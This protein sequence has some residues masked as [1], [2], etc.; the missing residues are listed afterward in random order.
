MHIDQHNTTPTCFSHYSYYYY[1]P[2]L[3]VPYDYY[4]PTYQ[5]FYT[6]NYYN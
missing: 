4:L 5:L 2:T 1:L 3:R 6:S